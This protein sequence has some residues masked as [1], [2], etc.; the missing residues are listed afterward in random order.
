MVTQPKEINSGVP[1][2]SVLRL[3]LYLLYIFQ[4]LSS[5]TATYADD[6]AMLAAHN[7][8]VET[9]LRLQKSLYHIQKWFKNRKSKLT[10]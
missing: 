5:V 4:S 10:K 7:N 8:H 6:I 1:Q 2:G 9:S 3:V